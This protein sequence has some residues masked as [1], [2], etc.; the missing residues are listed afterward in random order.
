MPYTNS[1]RASRRCAN[2]TTSRC[3]GNYNYLFNSKQTFS[4]I[5]PCLSLSL[6]LSI[7]MFIYIHTSWSNTNIYTW[8]YAYMCAFI[9]AYLHHESYLCGNILVEHNLSFGVATNAAESTF[10]YSILS[11]DLVH[12]HSDMSPS[13]NGCILPGLPCR[14]LRLGS[15]GPPV[16]FQWRQCLRKPCSFLNTWRPI[17]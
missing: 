10:T 15:R 5:P 7:Y 1:N 13:A 6:C 16:G 8:I 11:L 4:Q 17:T 14:R 3:D 2:M 9:G 12:R